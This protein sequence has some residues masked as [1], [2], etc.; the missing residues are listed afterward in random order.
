MPT[1]ND[2]QNTNAT[3]DTTGDGE[4]DAPAGA[5][6]QGCRQG[7]WVSAAAPTGNQRSW[8]SPPRKS[9]A[10][11]SST[12]WTRYAAGWPRGPQKGCT[13]D[14]EPLLLGAAGAAKLCGV[15]RSKWWQLHRRRA[16]SSTDLPGNQV[17]ALAARRAGG[18]GRGRLS[19]P[20]GLAGDGASRRGSARKK[21]GPDRREQQPV[22]TSVSNHHA[23]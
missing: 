7:C 4:R 9:R 12:L 14:G 22:R 18:L 17:P 2:G 11:K 13:V 16:V 15:S 21:T 1:S 8:R 19:R 5:V 20:H 10:A 23:F 3:P 6:G